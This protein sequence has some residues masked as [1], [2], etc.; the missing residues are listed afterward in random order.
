M[1]YMVTNNN[2]I[3]EQ[4]PVCQSTGKKIGLE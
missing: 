4:Q 1:N 2:K 3:Q